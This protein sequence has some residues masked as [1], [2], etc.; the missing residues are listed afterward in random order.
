MLSKNKFFDSFQKDK[1]PVA[2]KR[3]AKAKAKLHFV[4]ELPNGNQILV[5][6]Y[7][8]VLCGT[9]EYIIFEK[10]MLKEMRRLLSK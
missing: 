9:F 3:S 8:K 2:E 10:G 5:G 4:Y 6:K 1:K 7:V